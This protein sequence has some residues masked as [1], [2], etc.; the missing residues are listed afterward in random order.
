MHRSGAWFTQQEAAQSFRAG[1]TFLQA[2][3]VLRTEACTA[4]LNRFPVR[5]KH[6][7]FEEGLHRSASTKWNPRGHLSLIHI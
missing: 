5:P 7:L 6:H 1:Q 3:S 4:G 2:W